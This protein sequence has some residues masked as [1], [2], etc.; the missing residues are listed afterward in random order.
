MEWADP[1]SSEERNFEEL[2]K[3]FLKYEADL[4][5]LSEKYSK[6]LVSASTR[7]LVEAHGE[8]DRAFINQIRPFLISQ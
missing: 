1:K 6:E 4:K 8:L 2:Q 7:Q 3:L 5:E